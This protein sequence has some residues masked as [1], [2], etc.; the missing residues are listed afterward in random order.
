MK[1]KLNS[2]S[3][4]PTDVEMQ[5]AAVDRPAQMTAVTTRPTAS[6]KDMTASSKRRLVVGKSDRP[7]Q[8][9]GGPIV[10]ETVIGLD[11]RTRIVSTTT[12][13]WKYVCALDIDAPFGRFIGTG[14]VVA[15]QVLI[16]AGHCV[17]DRNQMGGWAREILVSPGQDRE[18]KPFGT[19]KV[20]RFS[21]IDLW[22][23]NQDP[24]FDIAALHL[25][26]PLFG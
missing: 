1:V 24:D 20:A 2:I 15:P 10:T 16:T 3:R 25:D 14:W 22:Q 11:E 5:E 23:Q 9:M 13:P 8:P 17:Y 21:T 12:A 26:E 18:I 19:R 7:I 4:I 6:P